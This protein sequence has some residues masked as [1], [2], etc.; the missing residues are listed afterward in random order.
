M[1]HSTPF[2][3]PRLVGERF[4]ERAIPLELLK[5]LAALEEMI[6]EVAKWRYLQEH[7]NRKRSPRGFTD[8]I[9]LKLTG[10]E[11]GSAV[12]QISVFF[13]PDPFPPLLDSLPPASLRY[14][15]QARSSLIGAI[16]A[17]EH[18]ESIT[19]HLPD[20]LLDYFNRI[21]RG[22]QD[23]ERIDFDPANLERPA[24][25]TKATR[26][27][28]ILASSQVE[29]LTD[30]VTLRGT[31]PAADQAKMIFELQ[32]LH[33][34]RVVAPIA[35]P[36]LATVLEA[37]NGYKQGARV[38]LQGVGRYNRHD[39]LQGI[40]A[41][42]HLSL[43]DPNDIASRL[44]DLRALK[45]GW[46]D[47]KGFAPD[48]RGLDWLA[49]CF[50]SR[51][52]DHLPLPYLYP[53]AEGGVQAEWSCH[54]HEITLDISLDTHHGDWHVLNMA[55]G[56]ETPWELDLDELSAWSQLSAAIQRLSESER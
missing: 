44:D 51:Y 45:P 32:V 10:I 20:F 9:S 25:L 40:D 18:N 30:D 2:L 50:E 1:S 52:P 33:G 21:G 12:P 19:E 35:T 31:I 6:V 39:R 46:L 5:D 49:Q 54:A 56:E 53:T 47:G 55:T 15:D 24:S 37:F 42:E 8:E 11:A 41:V 3:T 22:L 29:E 14:V 43:L 17:A 34:P 38:R 13:A 23:S 7:P 28:L 48:L 36:H 4:A 26:R 27:K 16:N